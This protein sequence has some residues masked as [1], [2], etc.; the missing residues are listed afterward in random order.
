MICFT[1]IPNLRKLGRQV[2]LKLFH[3]KVEELKYNSLEVLLASLFYRFALDDKCVVLILRKPKEGDEPFA[4]LKITKAISKSRIE[5]I[6]RDMMLLAQDTL[7]TS[8]SCVFD[9]ADVSIYLKS[10]FERGDWENYEYE[11]TGKDG[12][13]IPAKFSRHSR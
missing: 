1:A 3:K 6:R 10:N 12:I 8:F 4:G 9:G 11:L 5:K 2:E 7:G 13:S